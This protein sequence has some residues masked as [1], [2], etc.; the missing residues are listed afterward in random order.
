MDVLEVMVSDDNRDAFYSKSG[1]G[2]DNSRYDFDDSD[3]NV[4]ESN[5]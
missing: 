1:D 4:E 5:I 2:F 3:Y